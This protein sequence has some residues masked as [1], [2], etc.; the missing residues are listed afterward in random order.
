MSE[1]V[2]VPDAPKPE[3]QSEQIPSVP[4]DALYVPAENIRR[5][6][7]FGAFIGVGALFGLI[8]GLVYSLIVTEAGEVNRWITVS[9]AMLA[10]GMGFALAMG[11]VAVILDK[12]TV[13]SSSKS[14]KIGEESDSQESTN[15]S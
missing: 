7:K 14:S 1:P 3:Q 15:A 10:A 9:V 4:S 2:S 5:A 8:A 6:P 13:K 11:A 12:K